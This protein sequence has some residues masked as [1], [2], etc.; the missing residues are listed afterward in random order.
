MF[1][2]KKQ[3]HLPFHVEGN[4]HRRFLDVESLWS[5][6]LIAQFITNPLQSIHDCGNGLPNQDFPETKVTWLQL[7]Q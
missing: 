6:L 7:W 1:I 4:V 3:S 5:V 2:R